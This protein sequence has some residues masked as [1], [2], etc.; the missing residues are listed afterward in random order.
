[1]GTWKV[2]DSKT[3]RTF[4]LTGDSPPTEQELENIFSQTQLTQQP[5]GE[6]PVALGRALSKGTEIREAPSK[7]QKILPAAGQFAGGIGGFVAGAAVGRPYAGGAVGGTAGRGAGILAARGLEPEQRLLQETQRKERP[8]LSA[9]EEAIPGAGLVATYMRMSKE[10]KQKFNKHMRNTAF[11]E[12]I[13]AAGGSVAAKAHAWLNRGVT[14]QWL[15][16]RVTE[17]GIERGWKKILKPDYYKKE[18]TPFIKN[19]LSKFFPNLKQ[20]AGSEIDELFK[21]KYKDSII[22][23]NTIKEQI[24]KALPASGNPADLLEVTA[25]PV[26]GKL[27]NTL[28][29]KVLKLKGNLRKAST[30]WNLRKEIDDVIFSRKW[31]DDARRYLMSLR[32]SLNAPIKGL[33]DDVGEAFSKYAFVRNAELK[34]G[35]N[36]I[37]RKGV[38]GELHSPEIESFAK[39]LLDP[40]KDEIIKELSSLDTMLPANKQ[41]FEE[42]MDYA[43][44]ETLERPVA[45][46]GIATRTIMGLVG[47]KKGIARVGALGQQPIMKGIGKGIGRLIPTAVTELAAEEDFRDVKLRK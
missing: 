46:F 31:T 18:V 8:F 36:F 33:G 35:K 47:G 32:D 10:E 29:S 24:R 4:K 12:T 19:K 1:M 15:G 11:I 39:N 41:I 21:T 45:Q 40:G 34:Y 28:T 23:I 43:A 13:F 14:A 20:T 5:T 30:I 37:A 3:G 44:S 17:R 2:T 7:L 9:A 26:Q 6:K 16:P 42:L 27:I 22:Q 25:P 38:K